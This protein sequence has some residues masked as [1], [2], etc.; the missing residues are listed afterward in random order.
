MLFKPSMQDVC[1]LLE[2]FVALIT[3]SGRKLETAGTVVALHEGKRSTDDITYTVLHHRGH[4]VVLVLHQSLHHVFSV[5]CNIFGKCI[6]R[7]EAQSM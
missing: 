2:V 3:G 5:N 7:V 6:K 1:C 4:Y